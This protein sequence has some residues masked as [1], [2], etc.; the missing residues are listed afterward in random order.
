MNLKTDFCIAF[1]FLY[2]SICVNLWLIYFLTDLKSTQN[3]PG[4]KYFSTQIKVFF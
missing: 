3:N 2:L 4:P 1:N